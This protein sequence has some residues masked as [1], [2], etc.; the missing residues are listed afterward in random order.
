M[1]RA[2]AA[3][4]Y[5]TETP[6]SSHRYGMVVSVTGDYSS[7]YPLVALDDAAGT[8]AQLTNYSAHTLAVGAKVAILVAKDGDQLIIGKHPGTP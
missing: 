7:D 4:D 2:V 5:R 6:A 8:E 3:L 1:Q